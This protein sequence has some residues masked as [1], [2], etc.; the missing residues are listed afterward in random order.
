[1]NKHVIFTA[2]I[3]LI[4][5]F[6]AEAKIRF[7]AKGGFN[8]AKTSFNTQSLQS[9]NFTGFHIGPIVEIANSTGFGVNA[10][11]LY[12]QQ[13]LKIK[14]LSLEEKG[15]SIDIPVNLQLKIGLFDCV[16]IYGTAGPYGSFKLK[17]DNFTIKNLEMIG[18][19]F[20][21]K[22]FGAGLNFGFGVE[23][24][25]HFLIGANYQLGLTEDYQEVITLHQLGG[26][27]RIWSITGAY[28]F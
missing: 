1:M 6:S 9:D 22:S 18:S 11:V 12:S 15:S 3:V 10:A 16:G 24:V 23:L 21:Q 17:G 7:G 28:F 25:K 27:V 20:K 13:G 2:L 8:L 5:C 4:S 26:K 19:E 14:E